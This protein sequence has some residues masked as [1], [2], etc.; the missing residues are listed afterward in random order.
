MVATMSVAWNGTFLKLLKP[1]FFGWLPDYQTINSEFTPENRPFQRP[2]KRPVKL[3][4][5]DGIKNPTRQQQSN[6]T[7]K[8]VN[9]KRTK[10]LKIWCCWSKTGQVTPNRSLPNRTAIF[11]EFF[12]DLG[13]LVFHESFTKTPVSEGF[14]KIKRLTSKIPTQVIFRLFHP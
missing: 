3:S 1:T 10:V 2:K 12:R 11:R 8:S 4:I 5:S 13:P 14:S 6:T 9:S 7:Y